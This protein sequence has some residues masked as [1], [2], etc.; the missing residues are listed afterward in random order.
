[1]ETDW[2]RIEGAKNAEGDEEEEEEEEDGELGR[3]QTVENF[4]LQT[5]DSLATCT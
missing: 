4:P 2:G 5:V 1:M 3:T